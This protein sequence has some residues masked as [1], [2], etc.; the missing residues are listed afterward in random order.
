[1]KPKFKGRIFPL[2]FFSTLFLFL[3]LTSAE[4][5]QC[6]ENHPD[7]FLDFC[8]SIKADEKGGRILDISFLAFNP[9]H[10]PLAQEGEIFPSPS[11]FSMKPDPSLLTAIILTNVIQC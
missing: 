6:Q 10:F 2:A 3:C 8:C 9:L 1:M 7:E 4:F 5:P 11:Y